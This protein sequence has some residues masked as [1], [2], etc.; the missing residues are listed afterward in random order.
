MQ[1]PVSVILALLAK[2]LNGPEFLSLFILI[3]EFL[4]PQ[5]HATNTG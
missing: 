5:S 2:Q 4:Q 1:D 3:L